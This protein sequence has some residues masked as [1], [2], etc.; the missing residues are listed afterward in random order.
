[1]TRNVVCISRAL[2]AGGEDIGQRVAQTL[3]YRYADEEIIVRAAEQAG[4]PKETVEQAEH[5]PGL[6]GRVLENLGRTPIEPEMWVGSAM[7]STP[8]SVGYEGLI[9]QVITQ[10]ADEGKV[11]IVAH[12]ASMA[13]AGR[14]GVLRVLVTGSPTVRA[15]HIADHANVDVKDA[16]KAVEASD[17][18]RRDYLRHFYDIRDELPTHY[19]LTLN[20]DAIPPETAAALISEAAKT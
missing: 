13:L 7:L 17:K 9:K 10:T 8:A 18:A 19:D 3:G 11:V 6:I 2:A 15:T 12:G 4:V 20:T 1:M 5:P 14:E 16:A